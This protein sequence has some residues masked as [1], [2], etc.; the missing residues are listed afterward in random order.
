[1]EFEGLEALQRLLRDTKRLQSR[2]L[3]QYFTDKTK[4]GQGVGFRHLWNER[5]PPGPG[6]A[7][8]H[9]STATCVVS[10]TSTGAWWHETDNKTKQFSWRHHSAALVRQLCRNR[11]RTWESAGLEKGNPFTVAF[12]LE[13]VK[14]LVTGP[15]SLPKSLEAKARATIVAAEDMLLSSLN[16]RRSGPRS[17][18]QFAELGGAHVAFYPPTAFLTQLVVRA[19]GV[20]RLKKHRKL[21]SLVESWC[22]RQIEHELVLLNAGA[23]TRDPLALA[24]AVAAFVAVVDTDG[25]SRT[26]ADTVAQAINRIFDAQLPDGSWPR[27]R[28]LHHYPEIGNA[29]CYEYETLAQLLLQPYLRQV[30]IGK[31]DKLAACLS[32]L[33]QTSNSLPDEGKAWASGHHPRLSGA[34]SWSTASVYH[35]VHWLDRLLAEAIRQETFRYVGSTYTAPKRPAK[36]SDH[37]K[38]S[39]FLDSTFP[40]EGKE[41]SLRKVVQDRLLRPILKEIHQVERGVSLSTN[42][43]VSAILFGPP[44]TSKTKL[45]K[46]IA[47]HLGWPRLDIDPSHLFKGGL[48]HIQSESNRLFNMLA[49]LDRTVVFFDEFDEMVRERTSARADLV[50]RFLTTAML[51]KLTRI[52]EERKIVFLLATNHIE[53]FDFAISRPGR[54]DMLLPVMPPS[55]HEKFASEKFK[56]AQRWLRPLLSRRNKASKLKYADILQALTYHEFSE[57]Y[58]SIKQLRS[59]ASYMNAMDIAWSKATL[60]RPHAIPK[61]DEKKET[62]FQFYRKQCRDITRLQPDRDGSSRKPT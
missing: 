43:P 39:E 25:I 50:S 13:G 49:A 11:P 36:S 29:Y 24:Y 33:Y 6:K 40:F 22:R 57:L 46:L 23:N 1:M 45:A 59:P 38:P 9:A 56:G 54:F 14:A 47:I 8:S 32:I 28:P 42:A 41:E 12:T 26:D 4:S 20:E 15:I 7:Y 52:A 62:L 30:L 19:I 53:I 55:I 51:P 61:D 58:S 18:N 37:F 17:R 5:A 34:E 16:V 21:R 2:S 27:S 44:G 31:L 35:F 48:E 60:N 3:K 10:L